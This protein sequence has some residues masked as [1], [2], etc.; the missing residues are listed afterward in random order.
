MQIILGWIL[1]VVLLTLVEL[2]VGVVGYGISRAVLPLVSFGRIMV[3]PLP[4]SH[5]GFNWL[6]YRRTDGRVEIETT[7][8]G[9]IGLVIGV[10]ACWAIVVLVR[11]GA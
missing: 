9:L 8:A 1:E 2:F 6:G 5:T 11:A 4:G 10:L 3:Q 7:A